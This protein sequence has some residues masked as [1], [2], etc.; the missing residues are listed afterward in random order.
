MRLL[1]E[2]SV[3]CG[4]FVMEGLS[5]SSLDSAHDALF[6]KKSRISSWLGLA[7]RGCTGW[8]GDLIKPVL[9]LTREWFCLFGG[10]LIPWDSENHKP[11][12]QFSLMMVYA[13]NNSISQSTKL[14]LELYSFVLHI[15]FLIEFL[16]ASTIKFNQQRNYLGQ[17]KYSS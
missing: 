2:A 14:T 11:V 9:L 7:R 6:Q 3:I 12:K 4:H 8:N 5:T 13:Q 10:Y 16:F 17:N 15:I 1:V